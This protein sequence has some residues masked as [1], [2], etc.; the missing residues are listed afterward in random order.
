MS[1]QK[2]PVEGWV[3]ILITCV[4]CFIVINLTSFLPIFSRWHRDT[5]LYLNIPP[6]HPTYPIIS[7]QWHLQGLFCTH[8]KYYKLNSVYSSHIKAT[9]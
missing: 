2:H 7:Q 1:T 9:A 8:Y 3:R 4:G 5:S 6:A